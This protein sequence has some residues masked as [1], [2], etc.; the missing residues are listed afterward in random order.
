[1][2]KIQINNEMTRNINDCR[3][4]K[5]K[6]EQF[7]YKITLEQAYLLWRS[8]SDCCCAGWIELPQFDTKQQYKTYCEQKNKF[9][10][11]YYD[12]WEDIFTDECLEYIGFNVYD[13]E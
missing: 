11:K 6:A 3:I 4:I 9:F 13:E 1:M 8:Y 7:G 5:Q 2:K 12:S 10:D